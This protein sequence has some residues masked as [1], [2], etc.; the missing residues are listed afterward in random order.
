MQFSLATAALALAAF[1]TALAACNCASASPFSS[2]STIADDDG[3]ALAAISQVPAL[4]RQ[5]VRQLH[6][7]HGLLRHQLVRQRLQVRS[8]S[9]VALSRKPLLTLSSMPERNRYGNGAHAG[10]AAVVCTYVRSPFH[11]FFLLLDQSR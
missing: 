11:L 4:Q 3:D 7:R 9:S 8:Q 10:N 5:P 6:L 1:P 2:V